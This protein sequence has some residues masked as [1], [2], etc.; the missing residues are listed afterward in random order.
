MSG[1]NGA[2]GQGDTRYDSAIVW[3]KVFNSGLFLAGAYNFG[4]ANGPGGPNGSGPISG[5]EFNRGNSE[6]LGVGFNAGRFHPDVFYTTV[7]VL[8]A[9]TIG[10]ANLGYQDQSLGIGGNYDWG[11]YRLNAGYIY[12]TGDQGALG[13]RYDKA[14]TVSGKYA[15]TKR[16]DYELGLQE[17][18]AQNAAV[19]AAGYVLRPFTD[20]TGS[21]VTINGTRFTLYGSVLFHPIPNIDIYLAGDDLLT[22][23]GYLDSRANGFKHQ[24]ETAS[25]VRYKF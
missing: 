19:S 3:K 6:A 14:W 18:Y 23:G 25:G 11:R 13:H 10:A 12:Y 5:A 22:G 4:D 15:P 17:F 21:T 8:S 2:G 1:G 24:V 16:I 20:F 9:K 7:N